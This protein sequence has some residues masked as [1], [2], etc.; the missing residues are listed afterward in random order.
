M[1]PRSRRQTARTG[2]P[3]IS[4]DFWDPVP[5]QVKHL[6]GE[7]VSVYPM[8]SA[9][10]DQ[11]PRDLVRRGRGEPDMRS[12]PGMRE[13]AARIVNALRYAQPSCPDTA[14]PARRRPGTLPAHHTRSRR[15][16]IRLENRRR[17]RRTPGWRSSRRK[18]RHRNKQPLAIKDIFDAR[19]R[20]DATGR[21]CEGMAKFLNDF[22]HVSA[23]PRT[24]YSN[25]QIFRK[26]ACAF[27]PVALC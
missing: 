19:K 6:Y 22:I 5:E 16:R 4:A 23:P 24:T 11:S 14:R 12:E 21:F 13:M 25:F 1:P 27:I 26:T 3:G 8:I 18:N 20:P 15:R 2:I 10:G 7:A 17:H 9:A